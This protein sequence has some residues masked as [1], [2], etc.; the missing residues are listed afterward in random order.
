MTT[1][2]TMLE[3]SHLQKVYGAIRAVDDITFQVQRGEIVGFLGPNGA[4]KSTTMKILTCFIA[5]SEGEVRVAGYDI[6]SQSL[7]IR[8]H[9]GYLPEDTPLYKSMSVLE[10][11]TFVAHIREVPRDQLKAR[12]RRVVEVCGIGTVLGQI[13]GTL[14]KGF[15]QRVG[16]AQALVHDPDILILDEPTSGL[17]PNQIVEVRNVIKELGKEKTLIISTHIL[18]EVEATCDR[19]LIINQGKLVADGNRLLLAQAKEAQSG[20]LVTLGTDEQGEAVTR[21]VQ[22]LGAVQNA[23]LAPAAEGVSLVITQKPGQ[24]PRKDLLR[25]CVDKG[26]TILEL[27]RH[28]AGLEDLFRELTLRDGGRPRAAAPAVE[29]KP[30]PEPETKPE[31]DVKPATPTEEKK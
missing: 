15:R 22:G 1:P 24:D 20:F 27:T 28:M 2:Q 3:V 11:L 9:I 16:L 5:P 25:L 13:I 7:D 4:G 12:L 14:S 8:R 30:E 10:F 26:W 31:A 23:S 6:Y 19:V 18:H 29:V 17:D 21:A